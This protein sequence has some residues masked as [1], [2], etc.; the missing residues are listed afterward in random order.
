M[1]HHKVAIA[2]AVAGLAFLPW[3]YHYLFLVLCGGTP[4]MKREGLRLVDFDG[5][6][7]SLEQR[8]SRAI[9]V[10]FSA[11]PLLVGYLWAFVDEETLT[12]HDRISETCLTAAPLARRRR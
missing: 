3:F 9:T 5:R 4:G 10:T 8:R 6:S 7:A 1:P 12:W 2:T 11:A